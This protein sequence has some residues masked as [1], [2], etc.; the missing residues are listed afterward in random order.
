MSEGGIFISLLESSFASQL[1]FTVQIP[2][3]FR[4]DVFL[5]GESQGRVIVTVSNEQLSQLESLCLQNGIDCLLLGNVA[6]SELIVNNSC[7][8]TIAEFGQLYYESIQNS[9]NE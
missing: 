6:S 4:K 5:F 2:A 1:G 9:I 8:G 7:F 3:Q